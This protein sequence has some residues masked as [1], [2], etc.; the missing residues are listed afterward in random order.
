MA[1]ANRPKDLDDIIQYWNAYGDLGSRFEILEDTIAR[2]LE[3]TALIVRTTILL[4]VV[5]PRGAHRQLPQPWH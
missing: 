4:I 5:K 1:L 2:K 3:E